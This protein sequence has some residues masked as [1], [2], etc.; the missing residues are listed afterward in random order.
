MKR[1]KRLAARLVCLIV[2]HRHDRVTGYWQDRVVI[3]TG[4]TRCVSGQVRVY[5]GQYPVP[6]PR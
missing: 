3:A 5:T 6:R 4:C 1:L 2:G